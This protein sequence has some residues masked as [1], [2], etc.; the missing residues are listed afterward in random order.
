M[1]QPSLPARLIACIAFA[2][3]PSHAP[4]AEDARSAGAP[5][6]ASGA[7]S[8]RVQNAAIG[9][10]LTNA[11]V[12]IKGTDIV[13]FT[14]EFG[15]YRLPQVPVGSLVLEVFYTGLDPQ[16][17]PLQTSAGQAVERD[18]NLTSVARYGPSTDPV[19]LAAFVVSTSKETEGEALATNEQRFSANLKNVVATDTFGDVQ[20][21]NV[22]EFIKFLPGVSVIYGD[23]EAQTVSLR[24]FTPNLSGITVDG[25]QTSNADFHGT[26]RA[27]M[28]GQT[29]INNISRVEISKVPTPASAADSLGGSI[30]L[31]S[32]SAFERTRAELRYRFYLSANSLRVKIK[33]PHT[34]DEK[35]YKILPNFDFDYTLPVSRNFGIVVTGMTSN[36][37]NEQRL[38]Q[39]SWVG[40]G[41]GTTASTATPSAPLLSSDAIIDAPR[42]TWRKALGLNADWRLSPNSVV[43]LDL[44]Y[45]GTQAQTANVS[46]T[47]LTG[48]N[49][50]PT[51]TAA[52]GGVPFS[53]GPDFTIGATGRGTVNLSGNSTNRYERSQ[54]GKL[55]YRFDNG[56]WRINSILSRSASLATVR[57]GSDGWFF[58]SIAGTFDPPVRVSLSNVAPLGKG[59]YPT[60]V[61]AFLNDGQLVDLN[62][63]SNYR[64]TTATISVRD[65][66]DD[67]S[68]GEVSIRRRLGFLPFPAALQIG[69]LERVRKHD[70]SIPASSYTYNGVGGSL[71]AAP[72]QYQLYTNQNSG[73]GAH[74]IS[75]INVGRASRA[76]K[77][78]PRLFSQTAAQ[79]VAAATSQI[80][81]SEFIREETSAF[82][83]QTEM[84]LF[85]NRLKLL[86]GVRYEGTKG[87]GQGPVFDPGA[88]FVRNANG[89]FARNLQGL[90]IR[91]TEA[92][93]A[94][95]IE[96]LRLT[97]RERGNHAKGSYDGFYP[98]LHL[99]Y[100]ISE[101]FLARAAY[102]K[103]YGR[104]DYDAII[105]NVVINERD[106]SEEQLNNPNVI[107]GT[108]TLRNTN[109]RPWSADNYDLSLEYYT[110]RGGTF[111]AG[112]FLKEIQKFFA[113]EVRLSTASD[114]DQLGLDPRYIGYTLTTKINSGDAR[115]A[116]A[117]FSF[118]HS[119]APAGDWGRYF[120]VFITA[121]MLDLKGDRQA[122]FTGFIRNSR[123]WGLTFARKPVTVMAKWNWRGEQKNAALAAANYGTN[124]FNY[125]GPRT[126]LDLNVDYQFGKRMSLFVNARNLFDARNVL[127]RYGAETPGY[128]KIF[129]SA[130]Y[131]AQLSAGIKGTF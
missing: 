18:V 77:A 45:S 113:D 61:R 32:K 86:T 122:D 31:I 21:G 91:K 129:Q 40:A 10:Y 55:R 9:R 89:T 78:D 46:R 110:T 123:S 119:L 2:L 26:S 50:T 28:F 19:K 80:T 60:V 117:E 99:T 70:A 41:T 101:N 130:D 27:P 125:T 56:N 71:S 8:G 1:K 115:V 69:G 49:G 16:Q 20:E 82:Y 65:I 17:I 43:S 12:T 14:D 24:G 98:S 105:P 83:A 127:L 53:Y 48:T 63:I 103:T 104:P 84:G 5:T 66:T 15:A 23:A 116:G 106:L 29:S 75:F 47:T 88:V 114:V 126:Q 74:N 13:A 81:T 52:A 22:G 94:G 51:L 67:V 42:Y 97:R 109:L 107:P 3:G 102:A 87:D 73:F 108:I 93:A 95:S 58:S 37:Y 11:R 38:H 100:D 120:T 36:F 7:I 62:N 111:T 131:G 121:T 57:G 124:A 76:F 54:V 92:G 44:A 39:S 112:V 128:A 4:G 96:E 72:Y 6:P 118:R 68:F 35:T 25:A 30:N 34:F 79:V 90:R 33:D 85:S 64:V 59:D